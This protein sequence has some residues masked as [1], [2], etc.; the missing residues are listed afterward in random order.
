MVKKTI[1]KKVEKYL[2]LVRKYGIPVDFG[3]IF[4]S[5]LTG[6]A[7]KWS[8]IDLIVVSRYFDKNKNRKAID[9]LW[10]LTTQIDNRIEPIPV[11][12]IQW[13]KDDS[14]AIIE[15]ARRSGQKIS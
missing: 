10:H 3:I 4:G 9:L 6:K 12:L 11:G 13:A 15:I 1:A 5:Q 14:S 8:D 2:L 7:D